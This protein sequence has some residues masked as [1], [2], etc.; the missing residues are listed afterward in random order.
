MTRTARVI[1]AEPHPLAGKTVRIKC[2]LQTN[3]VVKAG[4][5][6]RVE[7]WVDRVAGMPWGECIGNPAAII[8]AV[9]S[10]DLPFDDEVL[11]GK[12]DGL[13][14]LVHVTEIVE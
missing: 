4:S 7:D 10:I 9:R 14:H 8:Y 13:G 2:D 3:P 12:V 5:L 6:Y 1:H 11:Y